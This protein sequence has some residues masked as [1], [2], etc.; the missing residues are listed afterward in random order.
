MNRKFTLLRSQR[1]RVFEML[2]DAGLE[3]ALFSWTKEE[4]PGNMIVSRLS[5]RND[6]HYFQFS[7]HEGNSW[8]VCS[9]GLYRAVEYE[10]PRN[11]SEQEGVFRKWTSYLRRET[12]HP[13]FWDE[14][15][16]YRVVIGVEPSEMMVNE[17]ISAYDAERIEQTLGRLA[18]Q[19]ERQFQL[20]PDRMTLV[21]HRLVYLADAARREKSRDWVYTSMGVCAATAMAL[22]LPQDKASDLWKLLGDEVGRLVH[23]TAQ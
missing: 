21:R 10:Y 11:W 6:I 5:Y 12:A 22:S 4:I 18:G 19:I 13:D 20:D 17:P 7:S 23:L 15:G 1:N 2:G 14:L 3:P 8:C 16:R 9:P